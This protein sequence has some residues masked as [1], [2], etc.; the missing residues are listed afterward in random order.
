MHVDNKMA[1]RD[2][3]FDSGCEG[4]E[5]D[6]PPEMLDPDD[7]ETFEK[8]PLPKQPGYV[9]RIVKEASIFVLLI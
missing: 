1:G 5:G 4:K 9:S 2:E 7:V 8:H 3:N 6:Y